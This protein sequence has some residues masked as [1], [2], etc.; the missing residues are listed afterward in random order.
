[1]DTSGGGGGRGVGNDCEVKRR[2]IVVRVVKCKAREKNMSGR[3]QGEGENWNLG[4]GD[5]H[6][7]GEEGRVT[8]VVGDGLC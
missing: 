2:Q 4:T 5:E 3:L 6:T 7:K 1:M 8:R